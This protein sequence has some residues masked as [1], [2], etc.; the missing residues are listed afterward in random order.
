MPVN[1]L[2]ELRRELAEY[3]NGQDV[4]AVTAWEN[5][6]RARR[7]GPVAVVSIRAC[8]GGPAGFQDYLGERLD[9]DSGKWEEWYGRKAEITFGVDVWAPRAGGGE[10]CAA[11]VSRIAQALTLGGPAGVKFREVSCGETEFEEKEG[12][13]HCPVRAVGTVFLFAKADESGTF[14]DFTVKGTRK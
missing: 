12:L 6:R 13:F 7:E 10:A 14:T 1:G 4:S 9:E 5:G 2:E 3:L 8:T 11:H